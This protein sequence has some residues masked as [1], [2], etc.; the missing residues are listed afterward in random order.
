M[1]MQLVLFVICAGIVGAGLL[2]DRED[3]KPLYLLEYA[4]LS[5][6]LASS[7]IIDGPDGLLFMAAIYGLSL[8]L[9][10]LLAKL[11]WHTTFVE[12]GD[13]KFIV[14][15]ERLKKVIANVPGYHPKYDGDDWVLAR[16]GDSEKDEYEPFFTR[17]F[18]IH[19]VSILYPIKKVHRYTFDWSRLFTGTKPDE[20]KG[21][22]EVVSEEGK[23]FLQHRH[24]AV[25]SLYFR[26]AYPVVAVEVEIK[27]NLRVTIT[28]LI[29]TEVV[30]P[31][32][33]VFLYK[34]N[35][36]EP[37]MSAVRDAIAGF[38]NDMDID[39]VRNNIAK[40]KMSHDFADYIMEAV[41]GEL[42]DKVGVRITKVDFVRYDLSERHK[43]ETA[44]ITAK[45]VARLNALAKMEDA[46][47]EAA[48]TVAT[49]TAKADGLEQLLSK[50][51]THPLGAAILQEQIRTEG[52]LGFR[53]N[54]LSLGNQGGIPVMVSA[55]SK[56]PGP[57]EVHSK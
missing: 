8:V 30:Y 31:A 6:P 53:G 46:K 47:G 34:G 41:N 25:N 16:S 7:Y 51:G 17:W 57:K 4:A 26:Y 50:A 14:S 49:L 52:L 38:V 43:A 42:V 56:P 23:Y 27:G 21:P 45:E 18:G 10:Y 19:W 48:F 2:M 29:T 36:L 32:R 54:V 35:W 15:G 28:I 1:E 20:K 12:T 24:E 39:D 9:I 3:F 40:E 5:A 33:P 22:I 44:A 13:I 37:V 55:D 11:D